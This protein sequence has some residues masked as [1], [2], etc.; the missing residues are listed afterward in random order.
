MEWY[1]WVLEKFQKEARKRG[2]KFV[3]IFSRNNSREGKLG[4][5]EIKEKTFRMS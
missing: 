2:G 4:L 5:K 1:C 3:D